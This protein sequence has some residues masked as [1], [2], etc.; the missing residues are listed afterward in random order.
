MGEAGKT[1]EDTGRRPDPNEKLVKVF[2]SEQE[3]EAMVVKGLLDSAGIDSD[4]TSASLVQDTFPGLGGMLILT[5]EEDAAQARQ[6]IADYSQPVT[7]GEGE[8]DDDDTTAE[9]KT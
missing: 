9:I 7:G 4:L 6:V 5:R 8:E 1:A 2:D 3:S